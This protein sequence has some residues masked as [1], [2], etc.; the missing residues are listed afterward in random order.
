MGHSPAGSSRSHVFNQLEAIIAE[1]FQGSHTPWIHITK[2]KQIA[3]KKYGLS[4]DL[5]AQNHGFYSNLKGFIKSSQRFAIY[6]T[7]VPQEFYVARLK[8]TVPNYSSPLVKPILYRIKRPWKV[9]QRLITMLDNEGAQRMAPTLNAQ[10]S[11]DGSALPSKLS[12]I[13]DVKIA[14]AEMLKQ[15]TLHHPEK[16]TTVGDLSRQFYTV[17]KQPI[18]AVLQ[19]L[20]PGRMLIDLLTEIPN[21]QVCK[22]DTG[23]IML[24]YIRR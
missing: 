24:R 5:A 2:L 17:Y 3:D 10:R 1:E 18:R 15:L 16:A 13:H 22:L 14:L 11:G 7:S 21:C 23:D 9:D 12:S 4:L 19:S 20:C 6:G 8:D